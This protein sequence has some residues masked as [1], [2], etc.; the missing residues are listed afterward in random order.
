MRLGDPPTSDGR[1]SMWDADQRAERRAGAECF[2]PERVYFGITATAVNEALTA[3]GLEPDPTDRDPL[4]EP[5]AYD[6]D[7]DQ[8]IG[9]G[10]AAE[11]SGA[12]AER[13]ALALGRLGAGSP[14]R[15]VGEMRVSYAAC[16]RELHAHGYSRV[17]EGLLAELALHLVDPIRSIPTAV[18]SFATIKIIAELLARVGMEIDSWTAA[19]LIRVLHPGSR[20]GAAKA[21]RSLVADRLA[22]REVAKRYVRLESQLQL[23]LRNEQF[24]DV[25]RT[26]A[27][28]KVD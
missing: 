2:L 4:R 22:E 28:T 1:V 18:A 27:Q 8:A 7:V 21:L 20:V 12:E 3:D 11:L 13:L 16:V 23:E 9:I 6:D 14:T 24:I 17:S 10:L 26:G 19:L 5:L 15:L 25:E